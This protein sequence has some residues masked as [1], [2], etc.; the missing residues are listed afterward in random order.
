M[1]VLVLQV[2]GA[3]RAVVVAGGVVAFLA[4]WGGLFVL[5]QH[6]MGPVRGKP[7]RIPTPPDLS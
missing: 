5:Q 1:V 2:P 7:P 4:V 6:S 3:P